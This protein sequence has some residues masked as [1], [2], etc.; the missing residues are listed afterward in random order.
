VLFQLA[1]GC[2]PEAL[3]AFVW[4][5]SQDDV[6]AQNRLGIIAFRPLDLIA[7]HR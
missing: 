1:R 4:G 5:S 3:K 2:K 6:V 7:G